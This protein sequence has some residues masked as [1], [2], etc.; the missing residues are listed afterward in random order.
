MTYKHGTPVEGHPQ[1]LLG[2]PTDI[3]GDE[4]RCIYVYIKI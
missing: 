4:Y 3:A 1:T 2:V